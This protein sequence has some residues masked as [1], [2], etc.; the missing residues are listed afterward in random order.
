MDHYK[1]DVSM[2]ELVHPDPASWLS[3]FG[4][5]LTGAVSEINPEITALTA[6][7]DK[8]YL[9]DGPEKF[10]VDLEFQSSHESELVRRLWYR[11]VALDRQHVLPVLTV[12]VLL[13]KEANSPALTGV[14]ERQMPDGRRTNWYH[15][16]VV[17]LWQ[18]DPEPYLNSSASLVPLAPLTA[19]T[20]ADLPGLAQRMKARFDQEPA[21]TAA[22]LR[23]VTGVLMGLRY[24]DKLFDELFGGL[25][26]MK[27]SNMYQRILREGR[28]EGLTA[29]ELREARRLFIRLGT[30]RFGAP[31]PAIVTA[32]EAML[33]VNQLE[34][35]SDRI[36]E[37]DLSGWDDLLRGT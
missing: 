28:Q 32:L 19:V 33:D 15:Y 2:N 26:A 27:E 10:L 16:H 7:V 24:P 6:S 13:R 5:E 22:L 11:Q 34:T 35:L 30:K 20:K 9:V 12:L 18:E 31:S 4:V 17:R 29:G 14:F 23:T 3:R 1:Y 36:L 21:P 8:V 25:Q 37:S